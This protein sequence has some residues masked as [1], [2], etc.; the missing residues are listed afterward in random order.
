[1][2]GNLFKRV[3]NVAVLGLASLTFFLVPLGRRTAF[4]HTIA[5]F[6]T[7]PAKEAGASI[8][9]A[10]H[11]VATSVQ[12]EVRKLLG[13]KDKPPPKREPPP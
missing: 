13:D 5:V 6:S 4:E 12:T 1:M 9:E 8:A 10:G 2:L 7:P 3:V 11:R